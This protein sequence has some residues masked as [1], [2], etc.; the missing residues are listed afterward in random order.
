[1]VGDNGRGFDPYGSDGH[2][3]GLVSMRERTEGLGGLLQIISDAGHGTILVF[4]IPI[5]EAAPSPHEYAV[6]R[7]H[8]KT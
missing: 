2:G 8:Q 3:H 6:T 1:V 4:T 7:R 5:G